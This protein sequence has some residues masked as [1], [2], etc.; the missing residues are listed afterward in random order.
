MIEKIRRE[1]VM[2][3]ALVQAA[4]ALGISFGL[5][6]SNEQ[7]GSILAVTAALLAFVARSRVSPV[8]PGTAAT[9]P[10][11]KGEGGDL[12]GPYVD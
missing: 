10:P 6:L 1:P 8:E 7:V 5:N 9:I 11:G 3:S 4:L 12:P 2:V